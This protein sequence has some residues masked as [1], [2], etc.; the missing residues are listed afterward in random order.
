MIIEVNNYEMRLIQISLSFLGSNIND[1]N[2]A[3]GKKLN[4][5]KL[6]ELRLKLEIM[7]PH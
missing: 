3:L 6:D 4:E 1:A 2:E 7:S 5:S